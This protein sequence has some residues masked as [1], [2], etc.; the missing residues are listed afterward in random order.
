MSYRVI[1]HPGALKEFDKLPKDIQ[2][3]VSG[4]IDA[5]HHEPRPAGS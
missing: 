4:I 3:Q 1:F 5:L 2:Q